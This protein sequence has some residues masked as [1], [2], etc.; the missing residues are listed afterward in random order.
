MLKT[1]LKIAQNYLQQSWEMDIGPCKNIDIKRLKDLN[2]GIYLTRRSNDALQ[3]FTR[4]AASDE[5][6]H[7]YA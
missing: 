3:P 2:I 7:T 1:R 4:E 5:S 6:P